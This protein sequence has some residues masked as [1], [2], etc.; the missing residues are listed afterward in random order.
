MI[1]PFKEFEK[2]T[3]SYSEYIAENLDR[4][5][6]YTEYIAGVSGQSGIVGSA[7]QSGISGSA[8]TSGWSNGTWAVSGLTG[9]WNKGTWMSGHAEQHSKKELPILEDFQIINDKF[10]NDNE[11]LL[12]DY[13]PTLG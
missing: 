13:F 5:I 10:L 4:S 2:N 8:G 3:I 12:K 6:A 11:W 7:G 9:T 1:K